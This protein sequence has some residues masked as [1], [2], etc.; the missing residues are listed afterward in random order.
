MKTL[1]SDSDKLCKFTGANKA[2]IS[3]LS[4]DIKNVEKFE[5]NWYLKMKMFCL[6]DVKDFHMVYIV[7]N[8]ITIEIEN[9]SIQA[10]SVRYIFYKGK[11]I[12]EA[13]YS[14]VFREKLSLDILT[15]LVP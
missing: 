7:H 6:S 1:M 14:Q 13:C 12:P 10:K 9:N 2:Q 15:T 5:I 11:T 4:H 8:P 3:N